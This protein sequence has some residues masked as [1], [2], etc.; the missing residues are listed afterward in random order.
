MTQ[1]DQQ[2]TVHNVTGIILAAGSGVRMGDLGRRYPKACIPI[3]GEPLLARNLRMLYEAGIRTV[4][5]VVRHQSEMVVE[6]VNRYAPPELAVTFVTQPAPRGIADAVTCAA[7]LFDGPF[8]LVLGD[9]Y[10]IPDN[11]SLG[12]DGL[13]SGAAAILSVRTVRD[14]AL[15]Q[16]ECTVEVDRSGTLLRIQEKPQT[17]WNMLKPCGVYFFSPLILEA[18]E[19]TPPSALRGEVEITDAIQTLLDL[20]HCIGCRPTIAWDNNM[21]APDD[22]LVSNLFELQRREVTQFVARTAV[23]HP[24]CVLEDSVVGIGV[25]IS[26]PAHLS[27]AVVWEGAEIDRPGQYRDCIVTREM[28]VECD[29]RM[30]DTA[31]RSREPVPHSQPW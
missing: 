16:N 17:P 9:T 11:L 5:I 8:V 31:L 18:I 6:S 26:A 23:L 13:R 30:L 10:F 21:T 28:T 3:L 15:I 2:Q 12:L 1:S 19:R 14:A 20:G 24:D 29:G 27:R 25:R 4:I 7:D 22:I